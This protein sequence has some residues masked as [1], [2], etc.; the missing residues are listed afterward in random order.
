[1]S[2]SKSLPEIIEQIRLRTSSEKRAIVVLD[3]GIAIEENCALIKEKGFDY[4]CVSRAKIKDYKVENKDHVTE[5]LTKSK[6]RV[7]LQ[8]VLSDKH[9]D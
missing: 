2:D 3:A 7:S 1:M 8:R 9:T 5:I 4:V 6:Q